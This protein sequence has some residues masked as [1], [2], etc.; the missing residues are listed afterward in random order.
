[1]EKP[2]NFLVFLNH[3]FQSS[4]PGRL[5]L[6]TWFHFSERSLPGFFCVFLN[7]QWCNEEKKRGKKNQEEHLVLSS[8]LWL[9]NWTKYLREL[10]LQQLFKACLFVLAT[11]GGRGMQ[12]VVFV[13]VRHPSFPQVYSH[14]GL[15]LTFLLVVEPSL[16]VLWFVSPLLFFIIFLGRSQAVTASFRKL[17]RQSVCRLFLSKGLKPMHA[18]VKWW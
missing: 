1:M 7:Q 12:R 14:R 13:F 18:I 11:I 16:S 6:P 3:V 9:P 8:A 10:T 4:P 15:E 2:F 17:L 5:P